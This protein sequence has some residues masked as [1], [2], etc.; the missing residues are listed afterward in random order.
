M[1]NF[2]VEKHIIRPGQEAWQECDSLCFK[3]KNLFNQALYQVRQNFFLTGKYLNYKTL[4]KQLQVNKTPAYYDLNTKVAQLVLKDLD[5][6]FRSFFAALLE[7]KK[8]PS[9]FSGSVNLPKYKDKKGRK[10]LSFNV[11]SISKKALRNGLLKITGTSFTT[12]IQHKIVELEKE[13]VVKDDFGNKKTVKYKTLSLK[14]VEITPFNDCYMVT[15]KHEVPEVTTKPDTGIVAAVDPGVNTLAAV[16][17]NQKGAPT[18][19]IN[20]KPLKSINQYYNKKLA[21]LRSILDTTKT[22]K[23]KKNINRK[24]QK[25]TRKRNFKVDDY[26]HKSS[27][28][29]VNL[30]ESA[31]VHRVIFGKNLEWKQEVSIGR[32]NNQNFVQ[33]PHDRFIKMFTYKWAALGHVVETHEESYTS[34]CSLLDLEPVKKHETY[35]GRRV[36]RGLFKS[37]SG[38]KINAD[39]NGSGNILRKVVSGAF[40]SWSE[41]ELIEGFV[42]NPVRVT[43]DNPKR[44]LGL[45]YGRGLNCL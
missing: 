44:K 15:L 40:D 6:D 4:Q 2:I 42:V 26:L 45:K 12:P 21:E 7:K 39:L 41:A 37:S 22:R 24:I 1:S 14:E 5:Q 31:G 11:Q 34:K 16:C 19:L 29:L 33:I 28:M 43:P 35:V 30:L 32:K 8:N 20:G 36:K 38:I 13:K 18:Y 23:G 3:S 10:G 27:R 17:T 9:K 25:L